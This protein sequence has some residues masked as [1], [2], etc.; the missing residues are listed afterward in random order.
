MLAS[1][2]HP[3]G[4]LVGG[5]ARRVFDAGSCG[6]LHPLKNLWTRVGGKG[7]ALQYTGGTAGWRDVKKDSR[8]KVT[9]GAPR[10]AFEEHKS[11]GA[12]QERQRSIRGAPE[13]SSIR[14]APGASEE[15]Q[16]RAASEEHQSRRQSVARSQ[17][18]R[19]QSVTR[20]AWRCEVRGAYKVAGTR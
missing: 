3:K 5:G 8:E 20:S 19:C 2:S 14:G 1:L 17:Q 16:R 13:S 12:S 18:E 7:A 10:G 9:A 15:H 6:S 4:R 11:R